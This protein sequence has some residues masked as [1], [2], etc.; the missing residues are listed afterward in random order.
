MK[1]VSNLDFSFYEGLCPTLRNQVYF[2]FDYHE[3]VKKEGE[4]GLI[5]PCRMSSGILLQLF[6]ERN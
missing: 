3:N 4:P 1:V 5:L 6:D 2:C